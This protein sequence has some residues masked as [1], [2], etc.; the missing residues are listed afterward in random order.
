[1][2]ASAELFD[3]ALR[4][5]QNGNLTE[6]ETFYRQLLQSNPGHADVHH[7]LGILNHQQNRHDAALAQIRRAIDLAP[8]NA[9]Y[10]FSMA[11]IQLSTGHMAKAAECC[12][13]TLRLDPSHPQAHNSLGVIFQGLGNMEEAIANYRHALRINPE[14]LSALNNLATAL[15]HQKQFT[16]AID[17]LQQALR[18]KPDYVMAH[19]NLGNVLKDQGKFAEAV[20]CF[21]KAAGINPRMPEAHFNL[22]NA[23]LDQGEYAAAAGSFRNAL[24]CNPSHAETHYNLGKTQEQQGFLD[25]AIA[26]YQNALRLRP[27]FAA[28]HINLGNVLKEQGRLDEAISSF[29]EARKLEPENQAWQSNFLY[30]LLYH[31]RYD[32]Q[33]ILA[34]HRRWEQESTHNLP[35][36]APTFGNH[37]DSERRLRIGYISPD[38][39]N[40]VN[41]DIVWPLVRHHEQRQFELFLYSN[42]AKPDG[43][44]LQFRQKAD[45][46]REIAGWLDDRVADTIRRD[47]IDILVDVTVHM[48]GNRLPVFARKSAPLQVTYAGYPGTTGLRAVDYRL[49]DPYLDPP[50]LFEDCYAEKTYRLPNTFWCYDPSHEEPAVNHLPALANGFITFGCLNNFCKVNDDVLE[51]WAPVLRAVPQARLSL[52]AQEGSHRERTRA[53]LARHGIT[54]DR[55]DFF[56]RRPRTEY[57]ALN[58]QIDIG[59][60]TLPYNGHVTSLDSLWMGVPVVTLVG[61]TVVGRAGLSQLSNLGL[62]ALAATTP[63]EFTRLAVELAG[64]MPRLKELRASLRNRMKQSP[65]MD[66]ASFTRAVEE[67]YRTMWRQ[68]CEQ[69]P[70]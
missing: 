26:S 5:H 14:N 65:L 28:A 19:I 49:T 66:A 33:A 56:S 42:R 46:W 25:E 58:H 11:N 10:H 13:Q 41:G 39:R 7:M 55:I 2:T 70:V 18:I 50:G 1:M 47:G 20:E 12:E 15:L 9:A 17:C 45:R 64:D 34:E 6:A 52:L 38:F 36:V 57:L 54:G 63:E 62:T 61:K 44:T 8:A 48:A 32:A 21:Q 51:L 22:G 43:V 40:H 31:P 59:L 67:A 27:D 37:P 23:L 68:W 35:A 69:R 29:Q 60:D 30:T 3:L 53:L 24:Q 4:H 16:E